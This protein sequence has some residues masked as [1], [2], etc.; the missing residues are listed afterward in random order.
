MLLI[1]LMIAIVSHAFGRCVSSQSSITASRWKTCQASHLPTSLHVGEYK[2]EG[3]M[4]R[5]F[6]NVGGIHPHN[7]LSW[8]NVLVHK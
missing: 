6:V 1:G 2:Y 7:L 4:L 3:D 8:R 5:R